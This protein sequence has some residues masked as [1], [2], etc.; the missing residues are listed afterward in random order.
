MNDRIVM[1]CGGKRS[2]TPLF[3]VVGISKAVS[4]L[5]TLRSNAAEDGR[6]GLRCATPRQAATPV[7]TGSTT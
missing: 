3:D 7:Q 5:S 4:P 6:S 1:G 2:A